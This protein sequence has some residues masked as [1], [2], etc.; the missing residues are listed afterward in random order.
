M[1][2][3]LETKTSSRFSFPLF[4][5]GHKKPPVPHEQGA[6]S[7]KK[8]KELRTYPAVFSPNPKRS[9]TK[10]A[11]KSVVPSGPRIEE[12]MHRS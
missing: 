7:V 9:E 4:P 2:R 10:R 5:T 11:M 12:L 3:S 6:F 1:P 8:R